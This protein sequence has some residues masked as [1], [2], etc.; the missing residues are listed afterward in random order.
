MLLTQFHPFPLLQTSRLVLRSLR[1]TD[2]EDIFVHRSDDLVNTYLEDFRHSSITDTVAFIERVLNE[3]KEGRTILWVLTEPGK[4]KFMGTVCFWNIDKQSGVAETGY[5][6]V[7]DY[8]AQGYMNEALQKILDFGFGTIGLKSVEA[9]THQY[10][11]ASMNL[12]LRNNFAKGSPKKP[13]SS[14]RLYFSLSRER[15]LGK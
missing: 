3:I 13:V 14:N 2:A 12:L 4:D 15:Y 7:S 6:L 5:T 10:N 11:Q 9:Y 8:H 1:L